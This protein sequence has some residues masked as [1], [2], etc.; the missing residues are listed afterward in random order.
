MEVDRIEESMINIG[1]LAHNL[2]IDERQLTF[3]FRKQ[4]LLD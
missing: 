4:D 1:T 2:I 3:M